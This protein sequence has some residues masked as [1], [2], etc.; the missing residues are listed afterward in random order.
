[1]AKSRIVDILAGVLVTLGLVGTILGLIVMTEGLNGTLAALGNDSNTS[2]LDGMRQTMA[3]LGTAFYTT[4]IGAM[5]GS[6]VL[7]ILNNV[8]T[9]NVDHLVSY[10]ASTAEVKIIP[11]LKAAAR[12][13][14]ESRE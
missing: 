1:M 12:T 4:L 3:G 10:V 14:S 13:R 9:S 7:R 5:F 6:V 11:R 2:L 8:Y